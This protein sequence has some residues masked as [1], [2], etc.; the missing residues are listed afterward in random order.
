MSAVIKDNVG[1]IVGDDMCD[2]A[3]LFDTTPEPP[4]PNTST[5]EKFL[6]LDLT[7]WQANFGCSGGDMEEITGTVVRVY[8]EGDTIKLKL[9]DAVVAPEI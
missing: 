2:M 6:E 7:D 1:D 9:K 3:W 5:W 8:K 4:D